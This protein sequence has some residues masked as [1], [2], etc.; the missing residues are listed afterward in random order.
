[1]SE[2]K[3]HVFRLK[4]H[5]DIKEAIMTFA[6]EQKI[7][8]GAIVSCVGSLEQYNIRFANQPEGTF[9]K[10]FFEIVSLTGIFDESTSHSHISISGSDGS[11]I[12]GHLMNNN[13]VY[14]TAEIV[15]VE[16]TDLVF[17]RENDP[18]YGYQELVVKK[19]KQ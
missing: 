15:V 3:Y 4:P 12:G 18:T 5:R 9:Q 1:M 17:T 7:K 11:T 6:K 10:G 2:G 13:L 14:T 16:L 8:A 19:K